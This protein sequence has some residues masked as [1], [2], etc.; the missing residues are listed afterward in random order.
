[1]DKNLYCTANIFGSYGIKIVT[2]FTS[3]K[4]CTEQ[5]KKKS[6]KQQ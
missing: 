1:M 5:N 2:E 6:Y 3:H 4:N